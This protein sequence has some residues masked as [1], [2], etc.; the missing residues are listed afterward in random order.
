MELTARHGVQ[1]L[2][3]FDADLSEDWR[4]Q[5]QGKL[6]IVLADLDDKMLQGRQVVQLDYS[7]PY[8]GPALDT[9]PGLAGRYILLPN[10][11]TG[12]QHTVLRNGDHADFK[13]MPYVG[14]YLDR[15]QT[16]DNI[17]AKNRTRLSGRDTTWGDRH[18]YPLPTS[19][20]RSADFEHVGSNNCWIKL[21]APSAIK[22]IVLSCMCLE[23]AVYDYASWHLPARMVDKHLDRLGL[24]AKWALV[25]RLIGQQSLAED[26]AAMEALDKVIALRNMLVHSKSRRMP[27]APEDLHA[28]IEKADRDLQEVLRGGHQAMRAIILISLELEQRLG[29]RTLHP[30]PI[31]P[32]DTVFPAKEIPSA[33]KPLMDRCLQISRKSV[34]RS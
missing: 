16:I 10:V 29:D 31:L 27:H 14:G 4:R 13:T 3:L 6:G 9:L 11:S 1:C 5:A 8:I 33:M 12:G 18:I 22:L 28:V 24:Y 7:Y 25:P 19:D 15:G 32:K 34:A 21:A 26:G 20:A 2:I 30:L 23:A 17:N